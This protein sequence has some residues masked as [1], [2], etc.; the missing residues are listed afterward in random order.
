MAQN[1]PTACP[2][3]IS[4]TPTYAATPSDCTVGTPR[5]SGSARVSGIT[6]GC[7]G[8]AP[9]TLKWQ[10]VRPA[11]SRADAS[12]SPKPVEAM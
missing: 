5:Y 12:G 11:S 7:S 6:S 10:K 9:A 4:G 3:I 2:S 8:V 1:E